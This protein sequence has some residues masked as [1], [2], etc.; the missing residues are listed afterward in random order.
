MENTLLCS[1]LLVSVFCR[2]GLISSA[3]SNR[4]RISNM[5]DMDSQL[6]IV[7]L[8]LELANSEIESADSTA[9]SAANPLRIS[10]WVQAFRES[11]AN[12]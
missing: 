8:V 2:P 10:L 4:F 1:I 5:F 3:D 9:D 7:K 6:T 11:V 12:N